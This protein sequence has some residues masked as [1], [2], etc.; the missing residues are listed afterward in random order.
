MAKKPTKRKVKAT[1]KA[2]A[3]VTLP[4]AGF[5]M[6][7]KKNGT[8]IQLNRTKATMKAAID[9]GWKKR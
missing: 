7:T 3:P 4:D 9:L 8:E 2:E 6:W 1:P 5:D